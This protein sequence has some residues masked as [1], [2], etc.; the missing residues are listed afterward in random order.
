MKLPSAYQS[1]DKEE[2][3]HQ[4]FSS[5]AGKYD[6]MNTIMTFNLDSRWRRFTVEQANL[7]EGSVGLDVCCGTGKLCIEQAQ[8]VGQTGK[9]IGL[10]FCENMLKVA[11]KNLANHPLRSRIE[12]VQG[13]AID[14]PFEDNTF[15]CATI[16]FALR[17]VPDITKTIEEMMRVVKPGGRVVSLEL[18]KPSAPVFKQLYWFYFKKFVPLLG[19]F[20]VGVEGPYSYLPYSVKIFP[21]QQEIKEL[22]SQIGLKD[23]ACHELSGG[24][25]AV[26]IGTKP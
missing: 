19:K 3:V 17:N 4:I 11:E 23:V 14:L 10:D 21:H 2:Y 16:G 12:L 22:F 18:A 5:I 13:N 6:W 9:V 20:R 26:H 7:S 8:K 24:I 15:D 25:V 1:K